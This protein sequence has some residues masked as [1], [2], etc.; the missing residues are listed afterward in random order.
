MAENLI[1]SP[2]TVRKHIENIYK[3]LQVHNKMKAVYKAK[4]HKLIE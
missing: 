4:K 1:I 3:K 2:S